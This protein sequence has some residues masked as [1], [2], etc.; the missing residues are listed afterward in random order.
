M[1]GRIKMDL[2]DSGKHEMAC[3]CED[4]NEP[5]FSIKGRGFLDQLVGY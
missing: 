5:T 3:F 4:R 1:H 2:S